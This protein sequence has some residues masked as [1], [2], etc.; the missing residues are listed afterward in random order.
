MSSSTTKKIN[1]K[2]DNESGGSLLFSAIEAK[3]QK[4]MTSLYPSSSSSFAFEQKNQEMT[5]SLV[6]RCRLFACEEKS[7]E[8][9][10]SQ[11]AY[12]P[13]L[14]LIKKTKRWQWAFWLVVIFHAWEKN[15][16]MMMNLLACYHLLC[17][18]KKPRDDEEP[19]GLLSS[20]AI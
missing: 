10:T 4:T 20:F 5:T 2:S 14:H 18:R 17:L 9:T 13:L 7:Q 16:E 6:A 19:F 8:M 1:V 3:W 12:R 11:E 15:K